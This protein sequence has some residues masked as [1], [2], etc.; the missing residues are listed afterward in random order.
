MREP[1]VVRGFLDPA[2]C[3]ACQ[4][5]MDGGDL[6]EAAVLEGTEVQVDEARRAGDVEVASRVLELVETRLDRRRAEVARYFGLDLTGREGSGFVR[7]PQGGF[8]RRHVDWAESSAWPGAAR[9]RVS[10]VV[11]L[12]S[13]RAIDPDGAFEGGVLRLY[14]DD[15]DAIDIVPRRGLLVA[16]AAT[17]PH[18]VTVVEGGARD[19]VVDWYY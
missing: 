12:G 9:R 8:Y 11:F 6:S 10:A 15:G 17:L 16:F 14:P 4:L 2:E 5:A 3:R 19:A 18:E 7:Y 13:S 1:L